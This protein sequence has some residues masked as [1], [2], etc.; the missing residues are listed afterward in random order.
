MQGKSAAHL[1]GTLRDGWEPPRKAFA[2]GKEGNVSAEPFFSLV[3]FR[4]EQFG[5]ISSDLL[6]KKGGA[7]MAEWTETWDLA[8]APH[9]IGWQWRQ[10]WRVEWLTGSLLDSALYPNTEVLI[11]A[12]V[13]LSE[14]RSDAGDHLYFYR[15]GIP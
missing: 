14:S 2:A 7:S 9:F 3:K 11:P 1:A 10:E 13:N 15:H 5:K 12:E 4:I 6:I 8:D